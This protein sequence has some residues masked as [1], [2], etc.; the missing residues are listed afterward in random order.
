[1]RAKRGGLVKTMHYKGCGSCNIFAHVL[2][3]MVSFANMPVVHFQAMSAVLLLKTPWEAV[4]FLFIPFCTRGG[5]S[6][7]LA[8]K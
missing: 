3:Q 5:S 7:F 1:M 4:L 8:A 6:Y 2:C